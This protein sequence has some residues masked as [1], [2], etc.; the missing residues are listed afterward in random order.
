MSQV[1]SENRSVASDE[2]SLKDLILKLIAL[3]K[4]LWSKWLIIMV[5]GILGGVLGVAYS[6]FKKPA[7]NA[8][9]SFALED[10]QTSGGLGAAA[11]LASQFGLDLGGGGGAGGAFSSDN[12]LALMKSR[13]MIE[14]TLLT[15]VLIDKKEQTLVELY[16]SFN[17]FRKSWEKKPQLKSVTFLPNTN[18]DKFSL[19]QDSILGSFYN[20]IIKSSLIVDKLDKKSSIITVKVTSGNELFSKFFTEILV[21]NVS[22][23]YIKTKTKK[24]TDNINV[25]QKQ[26]DSVRH[27]LNAAIYG[28]ALSTDNNPNPNPA[29]QILRAPS[30]RRQV[31]VQ[32]NQAI[33]TQLVAN[34]ELSKVALRKETPLIQIIDKP[35]LPLEKVRIGKAKGLVLGGVILGV[36]TVLYLIVAKLLKNLIS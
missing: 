25:L 8:E 9:L 5:M 16:I 3:R 2:I 27:E 20:D 12:I 14:S 11:G 34:L 36:L 17:D 28:V 6:L 35:I 19:Q 7:Y 31:D 15:P 23:F 32:A 10:T 13:L 26:T 22:D 29:L 24:S 33:L 4:Y 1:N 30:Q 21:K 18:R